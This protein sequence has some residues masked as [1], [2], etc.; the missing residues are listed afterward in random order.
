M[1]VKSLKAELKRKPSLR[2]IT[3]EHVENDRPDTMFGGKKKGYYKCD[4]LERVLV[5]QIVQK[6]RQR[7]EFFAKWKNPRTGKP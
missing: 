3:I 2:T 7:G 4:A 5:L 1:F 6:S